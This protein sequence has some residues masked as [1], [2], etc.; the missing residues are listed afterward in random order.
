MADDTK[1]DKTGVASEE[2]AT[3][4]MNLREIGYSGLREINGMIYEESKVELRW[5]H[6]GETYRKMMLDPTVA[7]V[8]NFIKLMLGKV[9]WSVEYPENASAEVVEASEFISYCQDNMID[10]TWRDFITQAAD[11]IFLGFQI[12]EKVWTRVKTGKWAGKF[13][14]KHL[15][16]RPQDTITGWVFNKDGTLKGVKQNPS[17][18]GISADDGEVTIPRSKFLHFRNQPRSNNPEGTAGL[19]GCYI[20]WKEKTLA[21]ELELVGMTKDLAGIVDIGVDAEYL[22]KAALNP[23]GPE[24]Q[25]IEQMKKDAANLSAGEQ[26][27]VITPIAYSENGKELFHFKLTGVDGGGKQYST[28][29]VILRKQNEILTVFL[30]DILKLGQDSTGSYALSDS[31]NNILTLALEGYLQV[32]QEVINRELIPQTLALN[33]WKFDAENTPRIKFGDIEERDLD[34]LS[35]FIQRTKSVNAISSDEDLD[36]GLREIARLPKPSYDKPL[37]EAK[38]Q[39]RSG[40]GM[41]SGMP[42]GTGDASEGGDDSTSNNENA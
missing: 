10:M 35:K 34:M 38:M 39:S 1:V 19:R 28:D 37:P 42:N 24:A 25:N 14:W 20:P 11:S 17:R 22:A 33:G 30:A 31:K 41:Q 5:P 40:D 7:S 27:Y 13:K 29:T 2:Q 18:F 8:S 23:T 4:R 9:D 3:S 16:S 36:A 12:N 26:S 15:P 6:A 32:I 21:T